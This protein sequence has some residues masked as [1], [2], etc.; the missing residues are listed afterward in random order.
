MKTNTSLLPQF[1]KV[2]E[3]QNS[4]I[5]L[6]QRHN[7]VINEESQKDEDDLFDLIYDV[8]LKHACA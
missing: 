3:L 8:R 7:T 5:Q 4:H 1:T 6:F 2:E